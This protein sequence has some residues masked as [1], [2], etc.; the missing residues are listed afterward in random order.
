MVTVFI[1]LL[2]LL[3]SIAVAW[4]VTRKIRRRVERERE[5]LE[6][7]SRERL[8]QIDFYYHAGKR[9][10]RREEFARIQKALDLLVDGA[11]EVVAAQSGGKRGHSCKRK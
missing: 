7:R 4:E 3:V 2:A 1:Y 5:V 9:E 11:R 8:D 6:R 10:G